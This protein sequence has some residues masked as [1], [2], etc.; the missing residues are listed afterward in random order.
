M[1]KFEGLEVWILAIEYQL[2]STTPFDELDH[3]R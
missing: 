1:H 3:D 2:D